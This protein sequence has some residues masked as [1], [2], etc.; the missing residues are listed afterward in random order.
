MPINY[1]QDM[2]LI[3]RVSKLYQPSFC[4]TEK[5]T[6]SRQAL[7]SQAMLTVRSMSLFW[8]TSIPSLESQKGL[9]S[10]GREQLRVGDHSSRL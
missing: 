9:G 4:L 10:E 3:L 7:M 1:F 8:N 2:S 5:N 6:L